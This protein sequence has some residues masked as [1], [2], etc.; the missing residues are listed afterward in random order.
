MGLV[1][2]T[3]TIKSS[4]S[5]MKAQRR[6]G[7]AINGMRLQLGSALIPAFSA[8]FQ[9][10]EQIVRSPEIKAQ[11]A[12]L[13]TSLATGAATAVPYIVQFAM[14]VKEFIGVAGQMISTAAQ[15]VGGYQNLGM[16][17]AGLFGAKVI[18]DAFIFIA[19]VGEAAKAIKAFGIASAL[20]S[21]Q[22]GILSTVMRGAS[23]AFD[24]ARIGASVVMMGAYA[25][26]TGITAAA[27][28]AWTGAQW[29]LNAA[30]TANPIGLVIAGIAAL[31]AIGYVCY[32]N[33]DTIK[34][35]FVTLW[36][37]PLAAISQFTS[38]IQSYFAPVLDWLENKWNAIKSAFSNIP[39]SFGGGGGGADIAANASGG[40]YGQ[41]AFLTTFAED[42]PEAAIPLDGSP[43]AMGLLAQTADMMGV[44]L[45]GGGLSAVFSPSITINGGGDSDR[46]A[47]TLRQV[48]E[49]ERSKFARML[50]DYESQ[51]RRT[52]YA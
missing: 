51:Q 34:A 28:T 33:W 6:M 43:R 16:I 46:M 30:L 29:L 24:V 20:A 31:I 15:A 41:G 39:I 19:A 36:D 8:G 49:E 17:V 44:P 3:E 2:S 13:A 47:A 11:I 25:V 38:G 42:S 27:T 4:Q 18:A 48:L 14:G 12:E 9:Q 21:M 1:M 52:S 45:G 37:D 5:M 10:I 22:G 40:I 23:I 50:Q 7:L 26:W 35:F 32:Q